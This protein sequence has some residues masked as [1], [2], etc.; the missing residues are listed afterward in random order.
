MAPKGSPKKNGKGVDDADI[1]SKINEIISEGG[2][3]AG[4]AGV[5]MEVDYSSTVEEKY[6]KSRSFE[7]TPQ[8]RSHQQTLWSRQRERNCPCQH[9]PQ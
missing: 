2:G 9:A 6:E 7:G 8:V 5:K 4:G 1:Q 3:G